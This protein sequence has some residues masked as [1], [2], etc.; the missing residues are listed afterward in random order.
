MVP[1]SAPGSRF[2]PCSSSCPSFLQ[3]LLHLL[4]EWTWEI[5]A[6]KWVRLKSH[7]LTNF[8]Q[9]IRQFI[10]WQLRRIILVRWSVTKTSHRWQKR[11]FPHRGM[12]ITTPEINSC[13]S[14]TPGRSIYTHSKNNSVRCCFFS[15]DRVSLYSLDC[16]ETHFVDQAG[17][18]LRNLPAS[19]SEVL[20]LKECAT[21]TRLYFCVLRKLNSQEVLSAFLPFSHKNSEFSCNSI[22]GLCSNTSVIKSEVEAK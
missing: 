10:L 5:R 4:V 3:C 16:P 18:E 12:T 6:W 20:G 21:T 7:I 15:R 11:F 9:S 17:H 1:I 13:L 2:L 22:L 8:V 19:A 14:A